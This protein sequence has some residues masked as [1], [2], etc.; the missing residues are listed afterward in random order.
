MFATSLA[1]STFRI[2]LLFLVAI[3][4]GFAHSTQVSA[5]EPVSLQEALATTTAPVTAP[6]MPYSTEQLLGDEVYGDF[7]IGPGKL[8]L[9][10][11]PGETKTVEIT[12][13]NRTGKER[14]FEVVAEDA[15][16]SSDP[17]QTIILLGND[18]GP[19]SMKDLVSVPAQRFSLPH[20]ERARI[21]VTIHIPADAEPGG[22]YGSMLVSTVS[23]EAQPGGDGTT[24]P[25]SAIVARIGSI[26]F[27]TIPGDVD[28]SGILKEFGTVG[29]KKFYQKGP[30][31]FGILFENTGSIHLTPRGEIRVVNTFGE[32]VGQITLEPWFV[33]PGAL[34]LREVIWDRELLFGRY[35]ATLV[36]E[37]GYDDAV[38]T[39]TYSFWILPWKPLAG[40]FA[41]VFFVLF[42][43]RAF[44][45]K[46]E[47]K[48]K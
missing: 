36:L 9:T 41:I 17:N 32:E 35:T 19:Y 26:F 15:R 28:K 45:K 10:I 40:G 39:L 27:I 8:E 12:V 7:V 11:N 37:R 46:F 5:Q 13:S 25:Q 31:N 47:F 44:F 29:N 16:G 43:I 6:V 21:P 22:R 18:R 20:N 1:H 33:L 23:Q 3:I 48:R 34:R 38:D 2:V 30:I 42:L 4:C 14:I 24:Q